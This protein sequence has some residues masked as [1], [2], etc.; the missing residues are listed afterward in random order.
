MSVFEEPGGEGVKGTA[1]ILNGYRALPRR[2]QA[3]TPIRASQVGPTVTTLAMASAPVD[4]G[5]NNAGS[6]GAGPGAKTGT[7]TQISKPAPFPVSMTLLLTD[8][9]VLCQASQSKE[10]WRLSP[11]GAGRY[12]NGQWQQCANSNNAPTDYA[13]A[14]LA[15]GRVI[16]AGGEYN[17]TN[18]KPVDL[19]AAEIFDLTAGSAGK[20]SVLSTPPGWTQIGDAPCCVLP[21]GTFLLG[22]IE[23]NP[24][25]VYD[26]IRASW[27]GVGA[28][29]N[30]TCDEETWTL[31]P[32][33]SVITA[34][35]FQP[36]A[37]ERYINGVWR[38]EGDTPVSLVEDA[39]NEIG[40]AVL[41]PS[42]EVWAVGATGNSAFF[43]ANPDQTKLG[44]WRAGPV[45]PKDTN[46][47]QLGAK[48]APACLL[49]SGRVLCAVGPVDGL[50][51]SYS[52]PTT[53]F[54]FDPSLPSSA[55]LIKLSVQP[56]NN[57]GP[58]YVGRLLLLPSSE[59][60][61]VNG[62]TDVWFYQPAGAPNPNW[63]PSIS[64]VPNAL[65]QGGSYALKGTQLNG[66]S[67]A[68]AY[69]DD[70]ALAT[71]FPMVYLRS[72]SSGQLTYCR[73]WGHSTMAVATGTRPVSTHFT[74]PENVTPGNYR[75]A[76]V[77]NGIAS[78][79]TSV[80]VAA[81]RIA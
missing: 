35:C 44:K 41:L 69:G 9:T 42:G 56:G 75:L 46:G 15:D 18:S 68:C 2:R 78:K 55:A 67:Q 61:F 32:D 40:P 72:P 19:C 80:S 36:P 45:F 22:S 74:V 48:D 30:G 53:F 11:D 28:K 16:I 60:M 12:S 49:P 17:S 1:K 50:K 33:G 81:A 26:P 54:E 76:V 65:T 64:Q 79:E 6:A 58:P 51:N 77:A 27:N 5:L 13:S 62:T 7:W 47:H 43:T 57:D 29:L 21:D 31:L 4:Q 38:N 59:V 8:G 37:T 3:R 70:A 52:A 73:T 71:N 25:A 23:G 10:W 34:D 24:C 39:S 14:T 20:W 63:A 66:L